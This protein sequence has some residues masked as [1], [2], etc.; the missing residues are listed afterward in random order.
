MKDRQAQVFRLVA[1]SGVVLG[2]LA[3][4][5][6]ADEPFK[7]GVQEKAYLESAPMSGY[8][9]YP[10]YPAPKMIQQQPRMG[11]PAPPRPPMQGGVGTTAPPP[12]PP[13]QATI[14][15]VVLPPAFLGVWNVA[16]QRVKVEA[17]PAFQQGAEAAFAMNNNQIWEIAGDPANGYMLGS[18]TGIRTP[19]VVDKVQGATAFIRYQHQVKNTMAQEAIVLQLAPGGAQFQGLERIMIVKPNEPPRAKVTYQLSGV[20]Q[21]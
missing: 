11:A 18:N 20:R 6:W 2:L 7:L 17:L 14:E 19:L 4:P 15:R 9:N 5:S 13:I 3:P 1:L 16:G 12:R 8:A 21:R 10:S